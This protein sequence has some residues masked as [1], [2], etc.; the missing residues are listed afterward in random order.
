VVAA[1]GA[2]GLRVLRDVALGQLGLVAKQWWT[3]HHH[4]PVGDPSARLPDPPEGEPFTPYPD[5]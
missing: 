3:D 4:G 5:H 1:L 2:F